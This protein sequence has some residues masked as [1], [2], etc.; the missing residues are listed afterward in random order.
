MQVEASFIGYGLK[1]VMGGRYLR[2]FVGSKTAQYRWLGYKVGGWRESVA[3]FAG[4]ARW[5]P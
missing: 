5:H 2:G 1:I 4:V 3:T